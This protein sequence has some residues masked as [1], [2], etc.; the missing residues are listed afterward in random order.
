MFAYPEMSDEKMV[1][2]EDDNQVYEKPNKMYKKYQ[3]TV[4]PFVLGQCS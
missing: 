1:V 3:K 2:D 4:Y